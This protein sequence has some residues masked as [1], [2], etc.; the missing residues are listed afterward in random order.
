MENFAAL[1]QSLVQRETV[2]SSVGRDFPW[3]RNCNELLSIFCAIQNECER[4]ARNA[5]TVA[6]A[7]HGATART[8]ALIV[9]SGAN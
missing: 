6:D 4:L 9:D 7:H 2:P 1:A 3:W 8:A 5:R